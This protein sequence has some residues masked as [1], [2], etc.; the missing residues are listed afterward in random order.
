MANDLVYIEPKNNFFRWWRKIWDDTPI[1]GE[2]FANDE[3]RLQC[4]VGLPPP[5]QPLK[6]QNIN[7]SNNKDN[8]MKAAEQIKPVEKPAVAKKEL[9]FLDMKTKQKF[10]TTDYE[11]KKKGKMFMAFTVAPSGTKACKF[12]KKEE[13]C[14]S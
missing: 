8:K 4:K 1:F 5:P 3:V 10:L 13:I 14:E 11:I 6:T 12:L 2:G 7:T 9:Q